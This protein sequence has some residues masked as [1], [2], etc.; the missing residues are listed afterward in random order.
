[1]FSSGLSQG[2]TYGGHF[3]VISGY[4]FRDDGLWLHI[5]D[6]AQSWDLIPKLLELAKVPGGKSMVDVA[7]PDGQHGI[8]EKNGNNAGKGLGSRYWVKV[9]A[10]LSPNPLTAGK[11]FERT[12]PKKPLLCD[13]MTE[14]D[15]YKAWFS[16]TFRKEPTPPNVEYVEGAT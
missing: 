13:N 3:V 7:A 11:A 1:I 16:V 8:W 2:T 12:K 14:G 9:D 5:T 15:T 4:W 6:P 10:L